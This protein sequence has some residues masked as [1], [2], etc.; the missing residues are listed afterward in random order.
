M[1]LSAFCNAMQNG[2]ACFG[3]VASVVAS[4]EAQ[5]LMHAL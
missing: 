1:E 5:D 2:L 3:E 4:A